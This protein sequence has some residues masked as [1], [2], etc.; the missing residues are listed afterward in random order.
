MELAYAGLQLLCGR[1]MGSA[2]QLPAPQ[3]EALEAAFGLRD[4]VSAEPVPGR[5]RGARPAHRGR[6]RPTP[7]CASSTTRSGSTTPRR[8]RVAFVARRLDAEGIAIVLAM[9]T[10][11][12]RFAGLPQLVV[13]GLGDDD[14][15]ELFRRALSPEPI[16]R[17]VRD[18]LIAEARG[19]PLALRELPRALS[20]AEIAGG[21]ALDQ[22]DAA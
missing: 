17:R 10:V 12:D 22:L 21:F 14:A 13:E 6:R 4:G 8:G 20:P 2:E 3:R 16:D 5:P 19:N 11:G 15:R 9:R 1:M 18:Q 7:C